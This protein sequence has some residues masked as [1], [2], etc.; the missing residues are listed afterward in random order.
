MRPGA[1]A[2]FGKSGVI[3]CG[4]PAIYRKRRK[5]MEEFKSP[6]PGQAAP[7]PVDEKRE[8]IKIVEENKVEYK[9]RSDFT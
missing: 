7:A 4:I 6:Y 1:S 3:R 2:G 9:G 8:K 5:V